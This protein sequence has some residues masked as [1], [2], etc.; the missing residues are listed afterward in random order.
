MADVPINKLRE[1]YLK[2]VDIK[3]LSVVDDIERLLDLIIYHRK[4]KKE[5]NRTG[6]LTVTENGQQS[7]TKTNSGI[8]SLTKISKEVRDFKNTIDWKS[9][10]PSPTG[11]GDLDDEELI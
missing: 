3:D 1:A 9:L 5:V 7:F 8:E 4:L 11:K 6:V 10:E 2:K